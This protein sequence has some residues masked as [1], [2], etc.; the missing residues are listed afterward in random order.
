M[1]RFDLLLLGATGFTGGLTADYLSSHLPAGA[2]WCLAGRDEGRLAEVAGRLA[3]APASA[4]SPELL[5]VDVTD[6]ASLRRAAE[7]TRVLVSTVGPYL[8]YGEPVVAACAAAGT[9]YLDLCGEP[10]F[11]DRMYLRHHATALSSGARLVH[12]CGFDSIPADLGAQF[13]VEALPEGLPIRMAGYLSVRGAPSGGTVASALTALSRMG[14]AAAAHRQRRRA[15]GRPAGRQVRAVSG[16]PG[17]EPAVG[18]WVLPL[19]TIDPQVVARSAAA[20]ERY[21]PAF[22]YSHFLAVKRPWT[23]AAVVAGAL[24]VAAAAQLPPARRYVE[25]RR[26][27]GSGPSAEQRAR[28]GFRLVFTAVAG[29]RRVRTEVSGGDP[30]YGETAKMLAEAALCLSFDDL[31]GAAG[32]L[33]AAGQAT[34]AA[35]MGATLRERLIRAGITFRV[36]GA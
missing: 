2:G 33:T 25:Q 36:L 13:T 28:A 14:P 22:S 16:R 27:S 6:P 34:P 21:G 1:P 5:A 35:A 9:D 12:C 32:G 29:G 23:A 18:A 24:G 3:A 17:F 7:S 26:P 15:E 20:L 4:A 30:G 31:P 10:E 11:V 19:P 8:R